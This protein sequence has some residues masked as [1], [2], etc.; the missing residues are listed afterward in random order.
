MSNKHAKC[1]CFFS[2]RWLVF[3]DPGFQGMLAVLEAGVYPFPEAWGFPSP[4]VGSL[5]PL[6]IV[7]ISAQHPMSIINNPLVE[8]LIFIPFKLHVPYFISNLPQVLCKR[9]TVTWLGFVNTHCL[10]L[11][12]RFQR[13]TVTLPDNFSF[14]TTS[15]LAAHNSEV[16]EVNVT[17]SSNYSPTGKEALS[18]LWGL[19]SF[20][21]LPVTAKHFKNPCLLLL[22]SYAVW[23]LFEMKM[24]FNDSTVYVLGWIESGECQWSQGRI[25]IVF[26]YF[27][28]RIKQNI[29]KLAN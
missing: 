25:C 19:Q 2:T 6:K 10:K 12:L 7:C 23:R 14:V 1:G 16:N 13:N 9:I 27:M 15:C 5:R 8:T 21:L 28:C 3:S 26:L 22:N 18:T 24:A 4:F 20:S 17:T 29:F 11:H